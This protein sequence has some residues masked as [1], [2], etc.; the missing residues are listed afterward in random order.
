MKNNLNKLLLASSISLALAGASATA[1]GKDTSMDI[2]NARQQAQIETTYALSPYLRA[3][4]I[5]IDVVDGK[6]TLTGIVDEEIN[7]DLAEQ[8]AIGVPGITSVDNDI[9]VK[10]DYVREERTDGERSF[11]QVVDDASITAA[12]KSKLLW[13][14]FS[15]GMNSEVETLDG[16]VTITGTTDS[17]KSKSMVDKLALGT[18]GVRS[19]DN[20]MTVDPATKATVTGSDKESDTGQA[21]SDTWITTKVKSTFLMSSHIHSNDI[22]VT[23]KEGIV[24]L[25]GSTQSGVEH[26]L[27]IELAQNIKGVKSVTATELN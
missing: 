22:S 14:S 4:E 12:V 5:N 15:D 19:V 24:T 11:G 17:E 20:Q 3:H 26:A 13:S 9:E 6:A 27:A 8:I 18:R 2:S 25:S 10:A 1:F 7:K 21:I 16:V 23:T